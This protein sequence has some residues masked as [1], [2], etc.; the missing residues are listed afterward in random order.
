MNG[1]WRQSEKTIIVKDVNQSPMVRLEQSDKTGID[2]K[3]ASSLKGKEIAITPNNDAIAKS[4]IMN[5]D[6]DVVSHYTGPSKWE[7][8]NMTQSLLINSTRDISP[9]VQ[10]GASINPSEDIKNQVLTF[11]ANNSQFNLGN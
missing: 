5:E 2:I 3:L 6:L 10:V 8:D 9:D 11:E 4:A 7:G 1:N